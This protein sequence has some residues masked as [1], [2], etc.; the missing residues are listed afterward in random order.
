MAL[1]NRRNREYQDRRLARTAVAAGSAF[2]WIEPDKSNAERIA[3]WQAW[4][5]LVAVCVPLAM[6]LPFA[7]SFAYLYI[8]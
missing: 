8:G 5:R 4:R 6:T 3:E 2:G 1:K 7:A